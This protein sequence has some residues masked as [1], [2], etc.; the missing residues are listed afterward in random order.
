[1]LRQREVSVGATG[2]D[3]SGT[4]RRTT[5]QSS[6]LSQRTALSGRSWTAG[7]LPS[8]SSRANVPTRNFL[9]S[10]A[11]LNLIA[12]RLADRLP[13]GTVEL[14]SDSKVAHLADAAGRPMGSV[15]LVAD[16]SPS[17]STNLRRFCLLAS[18]TLWPRERTTSFWAHRSFGRMALI[19]TT[20]R[21]LASAA[22]SAIA[23]AAPDQLPTAPFATSSRNV[24]VLLAL[25]SRVWS[26]GLASVA[27]CSRPRALPTP[28]AGDPPGDPPGALKHE[29]T[30]IS[31]F[32]L[33]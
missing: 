4:T 16:T 14:L 17:S 12:S 7:V 8:S 24:L 2:A 23:S 15:T 11:G 9:D 3:I 1:M 13:A 27:L 18:A 20:N 28:A 10:G 32:E 22:E 33:R 25:V 19:L 6:R 31:E 26:L 21:A 30:R 29:R 5:A